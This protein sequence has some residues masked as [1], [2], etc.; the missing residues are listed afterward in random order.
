MS[1]AYDRAAELRALD[2]TFSGIHGLVDSSI[3]HIPH[4]FCVQEPPPEPTV[5]AAGQE[6]VASSVA[7]TVPV[8]D[9]NGGLPAVGAA[10]C[11]AEA[12]WWFFHV[13]CHGV[14]LQSMAAEVG[15]WRAATRC[16]TYRSRR[17]L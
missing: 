6:T 13:T 1:A 10:I 17:G 3:T 8:I 9:L 16:S 2:A 11:S 12:Q 14:P 7:T 5:H 4:I 15:A